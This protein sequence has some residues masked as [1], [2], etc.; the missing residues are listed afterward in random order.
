MNRASEPTCARTSA[1]TPGIRSN[2]SASPSTRSRAA[3]TRCTS[4]TACWWS[5]NGRFRSRSSP[6]PASP[7]S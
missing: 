1:C 4:T 5:K 3:P 6:W 7:R 2:P